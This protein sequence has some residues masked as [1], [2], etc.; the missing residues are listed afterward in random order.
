MKSGLTVMIQAEVSSEK[1]ARYKIAAM[2][3]DI[4]LNK[5]IEKALD[6]YMIKHHDNLIVINLKLG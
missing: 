6:E 2:Q 3:E 5:L 4:Y 1:H